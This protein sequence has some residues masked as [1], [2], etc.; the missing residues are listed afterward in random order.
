MTAAAEAAELS[1]REQRWIAVVD[2]PFLP[3][4]GGGEQEHFGLL[5]AAAR[6]GILALVVMPAPA[7]IDLGPYREALPGIP[8]LPTPRRGSPLLLLHPRDPF[9]V[10]SRPA[11]RWISER[12]RDLAPEATAVVTT[13]YKSWRVGERLARTLHLPVVLRHQNREGEYHRSLAAGL[14]GPRRWVMRWEAARIGRDEQRLGQA[15]WLRGTADISAA[16]A[17]AR[18]AAGGRNVVH[19]PPFA[20]DP[21]A[22]SAVRRRP[23]PEPRVVFLG[24]LDVPT[25]TTALDWLLTQVW[26]LVRESAPTAVLDVV[27]RRP[28]A[29]LRQRL[30]GSAGVHLH[31]DVPDIAPFLSRSAVAVNPAVS[32]SGVNV[33]VIDY[34]QA[35][36]PLVSTSLATRGL[37][38]VAGVD[39]EVSDDPAGFAAAVVRLL[40]DRAAGEELAAHGQAHVAALLDPAANLLRITRLLG[41]R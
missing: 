1:L 38:L 30:A 31:A 23:D 14:T 24:A 40:A 25:N 4:R 6:A 27:G 5:R 35:G 41:Q 18:R 10:A 20:F 13:S 9:V 28:P 34:L 37:P 3:A 26:P 39:L 29:G 7:G 36:V 12:A 11:P 33:K 8:V 32:G 16:D 21:K 17:E 22:G 19:V 2:S 15:E